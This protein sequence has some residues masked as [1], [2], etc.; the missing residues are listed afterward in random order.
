LGI[1]KEKSVFYSHNDKEYQFCC[2]GCLELFKTDPEKY[3]QEISNLVVC[4]VCLKEKPKQWT[5]KLDREGMAFY[6]CR[7]PHC[8]DEF[9]KKPEHFIKRLAGVVD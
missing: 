2:N 1:T 8:V 3:L 6:F 9:K 4:P 7:C 5:T